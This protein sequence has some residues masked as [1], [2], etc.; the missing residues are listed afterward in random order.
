MI[1]PVQ[2]FR[3]NSA[4]F[5]E[6]LA[7]PDMSKRYADTT[8][9]LVDPET[10]A[11]RIQDPESTIDAT[12]KILVER[13]EER[14]AARANRPIARFGRSM[15]WALERIGGL[16]FARPSRAEDPG[17]PDS[18]ELRTDRRDL[19]HSARWLPGHVVELA[20]TRPMWSFTA[21]LSVAVL[22][23]ALCLPYIP[24]GP[25][26]LSGA[27]AP[28]LAPM[29]FTFDLDAEPGSHALHLEDTLIPAPSA[30]RLKTPEAFVEASTAPAETDQE[31]GGTFV[32]QVGSF[33]DPLNAERLA[34]SLREQ[35][36]DVDVLLVENF[37]T[38]RVGPFREESAAYRM[39][40]NVEGSTRLS[41]V[42]IQQ[43][44]ARSV[45]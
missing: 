19:L 34:D 25:S 5:G 39:A 33:L 38:V 29:T 3:G 26:P 28:T 12:R 30:E 13:Q 37:H 15:A 16:R 35:S 42:V 23:T 11:I 14:D 2:L 17:P 10:K 8:R 44:A 32:V 18:P 24:Y 40:A 36:L 20:R 27:D 9:F 21:C 31:V 22:L 41:P 1:G 6:D 43:T 7:N 4:Y 45:D